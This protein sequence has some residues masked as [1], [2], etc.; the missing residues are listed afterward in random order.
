MLRSF[1]L[2][3]FCVVPN[4][5]L[6]QALGGFCR[7]WRLRLWAPGERSALPWLPV[8]H[9]MAWVGGCF[10]KRSPFQGQGAIATF[11]LA[12]RPASDVWQAMRAESLQ[13]SGKPPCCGGISGMELQGSLEEVSRKS[14]GYSG[15][16]GHSFH[17]NC[18]TYFPCKV[19]L[20][21]NSYW[22]IARS[23]N[24]PDAGFYSPQE[25]RFALRVVTCKSIDQG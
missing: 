1:C 19:S 16:A 17:D 3:W 2:P 22:A 8:R 20:G 4:Q 9:I 23:S 21:L 7:F 5:S 10:A 12:P 18:F 13:N 25:S 11:C 15:V 14:E 24:V 6:K